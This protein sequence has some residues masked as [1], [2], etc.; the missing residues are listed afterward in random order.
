MLDD[1]LLIIIF[2]T[3]QINPLLILSVVVLCSWSPTILILLRRQGSF[4]ALICMTSG[5]VEITR[6]PMK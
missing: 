6:L 4:V 2:C 3:F 5:T 1:L